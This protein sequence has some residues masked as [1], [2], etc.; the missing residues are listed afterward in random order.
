MPREWVVVNKGRDF[1][2]KYRVRCGKDFLRGKCD[3]GD[4]TLL[5]DWA[6]LLGW[7]YHLNPK[8]DKLQELPVLARVSG[9]YPNTTTSWD[10]SKPLGSTDHFDKTLVIAG[11]FR[12]QKITIAGRAVT[13][14]IQGTRWT[15][16]QADIATLLERILKAHVQWTGLFPVSHLLIAWVEDA[17]GLGAGTAVRQGVLIHMDPEA[18][19]FKEERP[20]LATIA[21]ELFHLW[22]PQYMHPDWSL[23]EGHAKWVSE[24]F[25]TYYAVMTLYREGLLENRYVLHWLNRWVREYLSNPA[26]LTAT[27]RDF[28]EKLY[29]GDRRYETL[30]YSK[31]AVVAWLWDLEIRRLSKDKHSLD[32]LMKQLMRLYSPE[33]SGYDNTKLQK[34]LEGLTRTSWEDFFREH[35]LG[36]KELPIAKIGHGSG[37]RFEETDLTDFDLG[38]RHDTPEL[39]VQSRIMAVL[40][41]SNAERAGLKAGDRVVDIDMAFDSERKASLTVTRGNKNIEVSYYPARLL[42]RT[43]P[44][45]VEGKVNLARLAKFK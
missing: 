37:L 26:A 20:R 22:N 38:F 21:H 30:S 42:G 23:P 1:T 24:G 32:D 44:Q 45:L 12:F 13:V 36:T 33:K 9:F 35:I 2:L 39:G 34:V 29:L 7:T 40:P 17:S 10:Q 43:V 8:E 19:L 15:L 28:E 5:K 4:P 16:P 31:G 6:L 18:E 11:D 14:A 41:G 3:T 27:I 25:T